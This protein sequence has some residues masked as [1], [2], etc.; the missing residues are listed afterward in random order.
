MKKQ[1]L[2]VTIVT[3]FVVCSG[4]IEEKTEKAGNMKLSSPAFDN[5][6]PIPTEYTCDGDDISPPLTF[7][8]IPEKAKSLAIIMDDPDAGGFVHWVVW[9]IP[10]NTTGFSKGENISFPQ[11]TNDF[12]KI[13]YGGPCPPVEKHRYFFKLYALDTVLNLNTGATKEQLENAM[14]THILEETQLIGTY[15]R[16]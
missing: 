9:N 3:I 6:K 16:H 12:G 14:S 7:T 8:G 4:C 1:I 15:T 2:A 13:G 10:P 11:G 5:G